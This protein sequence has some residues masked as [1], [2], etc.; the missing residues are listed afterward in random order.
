MHEHKKNKQESSRGTAGVYFNA[1]MSKNNE[2]ARKILRT[3]ISSCGTRGRPMR[4]R[5][6]A[7]WP[8]SPNNN[9]NNIII[10]DIILALLL[11]LLCYYYRNWRACNVL[12]TCISTLKWRKPE[13]L[14]YIVDVYFN[15]EMKETGELA[16]YY[17]CLFQR[18]NKRN[19]GA[20]ETL[21]M[22]ISTLKFKMLIK[23]TRNRNQKR[24]HRNEIKR[25]VCEI[26]RKFISK[27]K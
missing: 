18:W 15:V 26:L 16:M 27:S 9:N 6:L 23:R 11:L 10:I 13:S 5:C 22:Y 4:S 12:R 2:R 14:Q 3:C 17:G 24:K 25:R 20:C 7:I 21:R 19:R 1:E 8:S